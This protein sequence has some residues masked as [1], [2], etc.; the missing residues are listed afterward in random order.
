MNSKK[1]MNTRSFAKL[2][3]SYCPDSEL[4]LYATGGTLL[5][6][7]DDHSTAPRSLDLSGWQR[8][9]GDLYWLGDDIRQTLAWPVPDE[10]ETVSHY[11]IVSSIGGPEDRQEIYTT[12]AP[13]LDAIAE[14]L[15]KQLYL[16]SELNSM[17][18][19]LAVRYEELNLVYYTD[20]E[21]R[22]LDEGRQA[23]YGLVQNCNEYLNVDMTALLM[24]DQGINIVRHDSARADETEPFPTSL[25]DKLI[26]TLTSD[27]KTVVL[28]DPESSQAALGVACKL[29]ASPVL[30]GNGEVSG[31]LVIIRS[32]NSTDF[33][34]S[35]RNLL[36]VMSGKA[37][38]IIQSSYDSLTG[39]MRQE[40]FE[41]SLTSALSHARHGEYR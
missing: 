38:K 19:E 8:D 2:L 37:S 9:A 20:D 3:K 15:G 14:T 35:D 13:V 31:V 41:R 26:D 5:W 40:G 18:R 22:Y 27:A 30:D 32:P 24:P 36:M 23:L 7:N 4:S 28:N 29:I 12:S 39:L 17:A 1:I 25:Q 10:Q 16:N 11:L 6:L 33:A 21:V 34:N